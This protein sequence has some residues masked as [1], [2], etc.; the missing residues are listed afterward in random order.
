[1][2]P[3]TRTKHWRIIAALVTAF[4]LTFTGLFVASPARAAAADPKITATIQMTASGTGY[5][6]PG[7]SPCPTQS[8]VNSTNG[9]TGSSDSGGVWLVCRV[10]VDSTCR[11]IVYFWLVVF[12]G[13]DSV[14]GEDFSGSFVDGYGV[15]GAADSE[16]DPTPFE[17]R[18]VKY[19]YG[20]QRQ[21]IGKFTT[22]VPGGNHPMFGPSTYPFT[23]LGGDWADARL[24]TFAMRP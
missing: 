23:M 10:I 12:V 9:F 22:I 7:V 24:D 3:E 5:C 2:F 8:F 18:C 16:G 19:L 13:V 15:V 11:D 17:Q 14:F 1:M 6:D 20:P 4:A 21:R